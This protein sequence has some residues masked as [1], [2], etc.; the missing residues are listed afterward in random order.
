VRARD[1][2]GFTLIELLVGMVLGLAVFA[3]ISTLMIEGLNDQS[4]AENRASQ[5][6]GAETAMQ[7]LVRNLREATSVTV[8]NSDTITYSLP[9][10]T[11]SE[12]IALACSNS[13]GNCTQTIGTAH[14]VVIT[15]VIN[16]NIF[17]ASPSTSPTYIG[18]TL[19]LSGQGQT[20]VTVSDGT[21]LRNITLGA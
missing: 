15:N 1:T 21:G 8:T 18:I 10:A 9:V 7:A 3:G 13:T 19:E 4:T 20:P 2:A 14:S 12:T 5:L 16:T 6:Q 17:T 11:G